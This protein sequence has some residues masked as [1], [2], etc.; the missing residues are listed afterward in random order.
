MSESRLEQSAAI[1]P[2]ER[3]ERQ[4]DVQMFV[5]FD[6]SGMVPVLPKCAVTRFPLVVFL[7]AAASYQLN[8][9]GDDIW[10]GVFNQ[11]MNVVRCHDV[12]E[13]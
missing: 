7:R 10:T 4:L 1:E 2:L 12:I 5:S 6:C 13:N 11:K 8:T 3:L 9:I